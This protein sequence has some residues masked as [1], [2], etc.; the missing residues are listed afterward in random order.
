MVL[1]SFDWPK[2]FPQVT[3]MKGRSPVCSRWSHTYGFWPVW[4]S[5]CRLRFPAWP[6][7]L[8]HCEQV[9]GRSPVWMRWCVFRFPSVLKFFPHCVQEKGFSPCML[10]GFLTVG[11]WVLVMITRLPPPPACPVAVA[12]ADV[13]PSAAGCNSYSAPP[14]NSGSSLPMPSISRA[15]GRSLLSSVRSSAMWMDSRP[16]CCRWADMA[17]DSGYSAFSELSSAV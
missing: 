17:L 16:L 10:R 13:F 4:I 6:K 7:L 11:L 5:W 8:P 9:Y 15:S 3:Q 2:L 1:L 12:S 14:P